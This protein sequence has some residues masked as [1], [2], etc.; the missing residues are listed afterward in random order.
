MSDGPVVETSQPLTNDENSLPN[1]SESSGQNTSFLSSM[2]SAAGNVL[3]GSSRPLDHKRSFSDG[4]FY[5]S[6]KNDL[7]EP[8]DTENPDTNDNSRLKDVIIEPVRP[9]AIDTI[10]KGELSLE[11]LGLMPVNSSPA[12]SSGNSNRLSFPLAPNQLPDSSVPAYSNSELMDSPNNETSSNY[13]RGTI[14]NFPAQKVARKSVNSASSEPVVP[15]LV[16]QQPEPTSTPQFLVSPNLEPSVPLTSASHMNLNPMPQSQQFDPPHIR[17][18]SPVLH[19]TLPA[20]N[21]NPVPLD[22]R[23]NQSVAYSS[24]HPH[25]SATTSGGISS[26]LAASSLSMAGAPVPLP[27]SAYAT[28]KRH[29][30]FVDREHTHNAHLKS[31]TTSLH[32]ERR[33]SFNREKRRQSFNDQENRDSSPF[34][35]DKTDDED[36]DNQAYR[37]TSKPRRSSHLIGFAYANNKRNHEFHR[38]FRSLPSNDYLLDDF[39]C[40]LS[41]DILIQGRM[42]VSEHNIC[43]NSNI[44]GWVTTLVI[45]FDEVMGLEKKMTAGLFPNAIT[46]QTLHNRYSFASFISRDSVYEFLMSIWKQASS[47]TENGGDNGESSVGVSDLADEDDEDDDQYSDDESSGYDEDVD[48][49]LETDSSISSDI[50]SEAEFGD[51]VRQSRN[52]YRRANGG[53]YSG[54]ASSDSDDSSDDGRSGGAANNASGNKR[55]GAGNSKGSA[56]NGGDD[57]EDGKRWPVSNLGPETHDPTSPNFELEKSEEKLLIKD[58]IN[59][60]LG[61]VANLLFGNDVTFITR[62]NEDDQK[63]YDLKHFGAFNALEESG[64]RQYE[65][66]KPINGTVGP[67]QTRCICTDTIEVWDMER[68]VGV[69]TSTKTPDVPSGNSFLTITRYTLWW[70]SNNTTVLQL[71]YRMEWSA[72][73]FLKGPIEKGTQDGQVSFAKALVADLNNVVSKK[74]AKPVGAGGAKGK[75][76]AGKSKTGKKKHS[77]GEKR[78]A[79]GGPDSKNEAATMSTTNSQSSSGNTGGGIF[80][81]ILDVLMS[82]PFDSVPIPLIGWIVIAT[83]LF[84]LLKL[85]LGRGGSSSNIDALS[86]AELARLLLDSRLG[87]AGAALGLGNAASIAAAYANSQGGRGKSNSIFGKNSGKMNRNAQNRNFAGSLFSNAYNERLA[88]VRLEEEYILWNWIEDRAV[89]EGRDGSEYGSYKFDGSA[90]DKFMKRCKR[91]ES[92]GDTSSPD[93]ASKNT[94]GDSNSKDSKIKLEEYGPE[95]Q[96]YQQNLKEAIKLTEMKLEALKKKFEMN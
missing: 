56:S 48:S 4:S 25:L 7:V 38:L 34:P 27:A 82:M 61:V 46:V 41:K 75:S 55:S 24:T 74:K 88:Q 66:T 71:S 90:G 42:Y 95:G 1:P 86:D 79:H 81:Q 80:S 32:K 11:S 26:A 60:P 3:R 17:T 84:W 20:S 14:P 93:D 72:R 64:F 58:T 47:R 29:N 76:K 35:Y 91:S 18:R 12:F 69:T 54:S 78:S 28:E 45:G 6:S 21:S 92:G 44:L 63:N 87:A 22:L 49:E 37:N 51:T 30:S 36:R 52:S 89:S 73:S 10:G 19:S 50:E 33:Y 31:P 40:A 59:A 9:A 5:T 8:S 13:A 68:T 2:L 43:F 94:D 15:D 16:L 23:R 65:Y 67:K 62:F 77:P 70:G 53:K 85:M 83:V 57:G 39:S 96:Y